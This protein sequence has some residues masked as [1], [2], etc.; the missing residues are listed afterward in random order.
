LLPASHGP[1][2]GRDDFLPREAGAFADVIDF[3]RTM[4]RQTRTA[5]EMIVNSM[6][7][8]MEAKMPPA[9]IPANE[10]VHTMIRP[11][12]TSHHSGRANPANRRVFHLDAYT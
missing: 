12:D 1:G 10:P 2:S 7:S 3:Q 8:S 6:S 9:A 11:C 4:L 5:V